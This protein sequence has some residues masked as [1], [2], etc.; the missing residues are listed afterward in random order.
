VTVQPIRFQGDDRALLEALRAGHPGAA[1]ALYDRFA[2]SVQRTLERTIGPDADVP[3]LL[4][5]V[6]VT[7]FA[8]VR[9]LSDP[10]KL[11]A[12]LA[13]I[14]VF[15]ARA[16]I[17]RRARRRWLAKLALGPEPAE[18][19]ADPADSAREA[20]RQCYDVLGTLP[21]DER[22]AFALRIIDGRP[23]QEAANAARTSLATFKRRLAR[24]EA[25]FV[26][27][28]ERRPALAEWMDGGTRWS[29]GRKTRG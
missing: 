14:A 6:F 4:Q 22:I 29:E 11:G 23:L 16:C 8:E 3:D 28:A 15:T 2:P 9:R 20:L 10:D 19:R 13:S 17:R 24:A 18:P 7:A 26:A 25:R 12:W 5:E 27:E 21:T 1:A